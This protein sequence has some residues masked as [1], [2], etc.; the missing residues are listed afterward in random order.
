MEKFIMCTMMMFK[1][2]EGEIKKVHVRDENAN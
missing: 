1:K 2:Q